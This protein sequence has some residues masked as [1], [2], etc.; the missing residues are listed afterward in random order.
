MML[1]NIE[2]IGK[3]VNN[4]KADEVM[5]ILGITRRTL[6]NYVKRGWVRVNVQPNGRYIYDRESVE[7]FKQG[8]PK[9]I[10]TEKKEER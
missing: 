6:C 9:E 10:M 2:E 4:M 7:R 1:Y 5:E 8:V 3:G